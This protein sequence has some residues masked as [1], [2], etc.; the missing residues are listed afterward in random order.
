MIK[1]RLKKITEANQTKVS[2]HCEDEIKIW[3]EIDAKDY[4]TALK[5]YFDLSV[6]LFVELADA[7]AKLARLD[8][9]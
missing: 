6:H 5:D 4:I 3:K 9:K 8:K 7:R 1:S 2:K